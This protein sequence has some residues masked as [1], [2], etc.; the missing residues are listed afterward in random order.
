MTGNDDQKGNGIQSVELGIDILKRI[1]RAGR[2]LNITEIANLC[3]MSKS[4]LHRYLTSFI[5]VGFLNKSED[6][7]Y[8]LGTDLYLLGLKASEQINVKEVAAPYLIELKEKLN[9]S[10]GL[11]VWGEKGPFFIRWEESNRPINVGIKVGSQLSLTGSA[12]GMIFASYLPEDRIEG[13]M[14]EETTLSARENKEWISDE[15]VSIRK[16]G[17][18]VTN[19]RLLPGVAAISCPIWNQNGDLT[20]ALTIVGLIGM[21]DTTE[22]SQDIKMLQEKSQELSKALG[23]NGESTKSLLKPV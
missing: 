16:R 5:R 19:G 21:L 10:V 11:A 18:A 2:P 9:Q 22:D 6:L 3:D 1:A 12:T 4:K 7:R 23:W 8:T 15:M 17:Y 20:A 13:L 14:N